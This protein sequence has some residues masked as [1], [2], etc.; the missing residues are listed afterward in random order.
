MNQYL[1][2]TANHMNFVY[3]VERNG[4]H[5]KRYVVKKFLRHEQLKDFRIEDSSLGTV[6][7]LLSYQDA[8]VAC[9]RFNSTL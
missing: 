5:S 8:K 6:S 9:E 4:D 7:N 3:K 1:S 2:E